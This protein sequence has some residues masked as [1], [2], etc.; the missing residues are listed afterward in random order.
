MSI[1]LRSATILNDLLGLMVIFIYYKDESS[2]QN[3]QLDHVPISSLLYTSASFPEK[4]T[5]L[6]FSFYISK[7][8]CGYYVIFPVLE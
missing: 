6:S 3:A 2:S 5:L 8:T 1:R 4:I 7:Q